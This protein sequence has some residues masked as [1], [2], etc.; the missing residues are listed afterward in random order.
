MGRVYVARVDEPGPEAAAEALGTAL[1]ALGDLPGGD[2]SLLAPLRGDLARDERRLEEALRAALPQ[3]PARLRSVAQ[4]GELARYQLS[5]PDR[6][7]RIE[8]LHSL[9]SAGP[10][11]W[12]GPLRWDAVLGGPGGALAAAADAALPAALDPSRLVDALS[13]LLEVGD[14][15]VV[16]GDGRRVALGAAADA[17]REHH[18]GLLLVADNALAHDVVW[19]WMLGEDPAWIA[20]LAERGFG[21]SRM[22]D[23]ELLGA[24]VAPFRRRLEGFG[25][26]PEFRRMG[27]AF[28]RLTGVSLPV[29]VLPCS[30]GPAAA[31]AEAWLACHT[32]DPV[33]REA[34]KEVP[35]FSLLA[36]AREPG[37]VPE[38]PRV[39]AVGPD[40]GPAV[41]GDVHVD[42]AHRRSSL[43]AFF[44]RSSATVWDLRL[45]D[46]RRVRLAALEEAAPSPE[47][48]GRAAAMLTGDRRLREP[49]ESRWGAVWSWI[50]RRVRR[51]S[52]PAPVV[53]A[54][55][56]RRL[57]ERPWRR[58]RLAGP[59]LRDPDGAPSTGG[60]DG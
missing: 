40:A 37:S 10:L 24:D 15:E 30:P 17:P 1:A 21:P 9:Y 56:I 4:G 32:E 43:P 5:V 23:V 20:A 25:R 35:P 8:A 49:R 16:V 47:R 58:P 38:H 19:A 42:K 34:L 52:I 55:K 51:V 3:A 28:Q 41:L 2:W 7:R 31:Q 48:I 29:E 46:G 44:R 18:L 13:G 14:P 50:V 57:T 39:L 33:R 53:H 27:A 6:G 54:R 36:G 11:A 26:P 45:A 22:E 59:A 12:L 60:V